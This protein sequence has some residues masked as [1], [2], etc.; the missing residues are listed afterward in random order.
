MNQIDEYDAGLKNIIEAISESCA[1]EE[2]LEYIE[3][4]RVV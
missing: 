1:K 4:R 2:H 3:W